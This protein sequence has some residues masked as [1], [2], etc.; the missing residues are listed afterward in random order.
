MTLMRELTDGV[1]Q[2]KDTETG[3][4]I[5]YPDETPAF[6]RKMYSCYSSDGVRVITTNQARVAFAWVSDD[7]R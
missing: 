5:Q 7:D 1:V 2:V 4:Y 6:T 3:K